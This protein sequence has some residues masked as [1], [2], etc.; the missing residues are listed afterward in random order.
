MYG[1]G[2]LGVETMDILQSAI[3]HGSEKPHRLAFL[4]DDPRREEVLG[5]PVTAVGRHVAGAKVTIAVGEPSDRA[6]LAEKVR[7]LDLRL[8]SIVSPLAFVSRHAEIGDGV[9]VAPY[10][11]VQATARI[12]RNVA[13]NTASIVGHDVVVEDNC[14]LSSMVNLGGGVHIETL[15]YV[16]MGALIKEKLRVGCSS[17]VGM[18]AVVHSDVPK[19]VITVGNP[20]RVVRRN[21][22][23]KVFR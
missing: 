19:E 18:G 17:I 4:V 6:A 7:M 10:V 20:A 13:I 12:G 2:G 23:R 1:A 16:G 5:L 15:S 3:N 22:D 21:E 11:S 14:V 8:A 9:I